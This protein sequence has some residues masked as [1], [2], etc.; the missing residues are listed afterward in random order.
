[1][2]KALSALLLAAMLL[3]MCPVYATEETAVAENETTIT[4]VEQNTTS[5]EET[6]DVSSTPTKEFFD[7]KTE[8][9]DDTTQATEKNTDKAI[10]DGDTK[11]TGKLAIYMSLIDHP[12]M[13]DTA[14]RVDVYKKDGTHIGW[15]DAWVGGITKQITLDVNLSDFEPDTEI[16]AKF[17][18]LRYVTYEG[19]EY[20]PNQEV[21]LK[22]TS[23]AQKNEF[24]MTGDKPY[25]LQPVI[26]TPNEGLQKFSPAATIIDNTTYVPAIAFA[27]KMGL[28]AEKN[29]KY[30]SMAI[31]V[32]NKCVAYNIGSTI[33]N[34]FGKDIVMNAPTKEIN[35]TVFIP[36][37][38]FAEH[39]DCS[40]KVLDF[41]DHIDVVL[42]ESSIA[43]AEYEKY[44][45]NKNNISSK[46]K[47]MIHVDKSDYRVR[48]YKGAKNHWVQVKS[49]PCAI[50][51]PWTPT[52]TGEFEYFSKESIWPYNG[53][54]VGPIM[55]FYGGYALHSTLRYYGGGEYDGRVGVMISHGCVRLHPADI[56]WM[57]N[58]IPLKT[59]IYITE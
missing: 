54:F 56:T 23:D 37:R 35:G 40:L 39:F 58:N 59:K 4:Q 33:T 36:V 43:K 6:G 12:I 5:Q 15:D 32:G 50:G 11:T 20:K 47:W 52:I 26:Y 38:A 14:A 48:V 51:A 30:N 13:V 55:R 21:I 57:W 9:T 22:T 44:P 53:Y 27:E 45:V 10:D 42:G 8:D 31:S 49:Y 29:T 17:T 25:K 3:G 1:M 19:K 24:N 41:G 28:M 18:G 7:E 34:V 16:I 2:K 46:T